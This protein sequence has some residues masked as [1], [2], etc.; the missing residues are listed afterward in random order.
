MGQTKIT[1]PKF[2]GIP[3][4]S[5]GSGHAPAIMQ[6]EFWI[7]GQLSFIKNY[8]EAKINGHKYKLLDSGEPA[9]PGYCIPD[10]VRE[11]W[12]SLYKVHKRKLKP[13]I[14]KGMT[15]SQVRKLL[16]EKKNCK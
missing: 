8:G 11:D 3:E 5:D 9:Q 12:C 13:Y 4:I 2:G 16:K 14:L 10:L 7:N 15:P 6:F 1:I